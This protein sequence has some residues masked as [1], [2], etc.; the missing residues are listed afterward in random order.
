M[1]YVIIGIISIFTILLTT[2]WFLSR[3]R[4][5]QTIEHFGFLSRMKDQLQSQMEA[6]TAAIQEQATAQA[7]SQASSQA[8]AQQLQQELAA[9][10]AAEAPTTEEAPTEESADDVVP[11]QNQQNDSIKGPT[12]WKNDNNYNN[13]TGYN[14]NLNGNLIFNDEVVFKNQNVSFQE[15]VYFNNDIYLY[16]NSLM[17]GQGGSSNQLSMDSYKDTRTHINA[18]NNAFTDDDYAL[19]QDDLDELKR[20]GLEKKAEANEECNYFDLNKDHQSCA[21]KIWRRLRSKDIED[22]PVCNCCCSPD[23]DETNCIVQLIKSNNKDPYVLQL[24]AKGDILYKIMNTGTQDD[25]VQISLQ[26]SG[27]LQTCKLL[28]FN[29][30]KMTGDTDN[31]TGLVKIMFNDEFDGNIIAYPK[32]L[33]IQSIKLIIE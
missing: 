25:F 2:I 21:N 16:G 12:I 19:E 4:K 26:K 11:T 13:L 29:V 14:M 1:F 10:A 6:A 30:E 24:E 22:A 33:G 3:G 8:Q 28:F 18:L 23:T 32:D 15:P 5:K 17:F 31:R 7:S 9:E 20:I 27:N